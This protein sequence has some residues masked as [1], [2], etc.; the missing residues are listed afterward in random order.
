MQRL[1]VPGFDLDPGL[2]LEA[3]ARE[4]DQE[5]APRPRDR[6]GWVLAP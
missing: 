5:G 3:E 4:T 6:G 2:A 1:A